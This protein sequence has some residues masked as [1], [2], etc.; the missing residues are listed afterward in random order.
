MTTR[1]RQIEVQRI[2][3]LQGATVSGVDLRQLSRDASAE[4]QRA[5]VEH[6]IL[7]FR[8]QGLSGE[9]FAGFTRLFGPASAEDIVP[10]DGNPST[11]GAIH[12]RENERQKIN[13]WHM[14]HSFRADPAPVLALHAKSLPSCGGDTL[15]ASL[16]SAYDGLSDRTKAQIEGLVAVHQMTPT[17]NTARRH[18]EAEIE[19]M[20]QV[21]VRHPLVGF[22][23][24]NG[25][26]FLFVNMPQYC[27]YIE[28][29]AQSESDALLDKLYR[30]AQRPEFHIRVTWE[31]ETLVVWENSHCLHY[32]VADY[33]PESRKLYR[34]AIKG[35]PILPVP[36]VAF[37]SEAAQSAPTTETA[38]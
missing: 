15:F 34:V 32:P 5:L 26:R 13:F 21:K 31:P 38:P 36:G 17:Q 18:S 4:I 19:R 10:I 16:E 27:R 8:D 1:Y 25:R 11:V 20:L 6:K 35:Q 24:E 2:S 7:V 30:H 23:P 14:D 28:G 37:T 22:N 3:P 12:I 9:E 33:F 29:V